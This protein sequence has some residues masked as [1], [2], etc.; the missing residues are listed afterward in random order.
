MNSSH[1]VT[2]RH[3]WDIETI[4]FVIL[5]TILGA[6][7]RLAPVLSTDFPLNDGALF[8]VM[9]R[10][11][12]N[13]NYLL[14]KYVSFNAL[15]IP[16]AYPPLGFYIAGSI[17]DLL[18]LQL[19]D[20]VRVIPAIFSILT[21]PVFYLLGNEILPKKSQVMV[22]VF[23]FALV[24]RSFEWMI[25]GG[26]LT[27]APGFLFSILAVYF[28][29]LMYTR[30]A[31][32]Y[33]ILTIIFS[34]LCVL[35]HPEMAWNV[36]LAAFLFFI[37][38]NHSRKAL[39]KSILVA[40]GVLL[41][42]APWWLSL[43][44]THGITPLIAGFR[45]GYGAF[46][47]LG[48][49]LRLNFGDELFLQLVS[50]LALL[51]I[52]ISVFKKELL[53][54]VWLAAIIILSPRGGSTNATVPLSML[55]GIGMDVVIAAGVSLT[56]AIGSK[57]NNTPKNI[58][59][60]FDQLMQHRFS[61]WFLGF[62]IIYLL[63]MAVILP[64]F[65]PETLSAISNEEREAMHWVADNTLIDSRFVVLTSLD[66]FWVDAVSEW[67]PVLSNRENLVL[68]QG[69][70][71]IQGGFSSK[72]LGYIQLQRCASTES[73]CL[74]DWSDSHNESFTHVYISKYQPGRK[75][76]QRGLY[77]SLKNTDG[78]DLVYDTEDVAIFEKQ[79]VDE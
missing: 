32:K 47:I 49:F 51:G 44:I 37:F 64:V 14:P 33:V 63:I 10:D 26:G 8:T 23:A 3:S 77:I 55:A 40:I 25:M 50:I 24:P 41:I 38:I 12:L 46:S 2:R 54:P 65:R 15:Q 16:F 74:E 61:K 53:L 7:V 60:G 58:H 35:S 11:L 56:T 70:E 13:A 4:A 66:A 57:D 79:Q 34:S 27:R 62:F 9:V 42:T 75:P 71:W 48:S 29:Y 5:A 28:V 36:L 22:A 45:S 39:L 31:N 1:G 68:V 72:W 76:A 73:S 43:L 52:F 78:Y 18:N 20:V 30:L 6:Y 69:S 59:S 17:T 19:I 21:I 67:F